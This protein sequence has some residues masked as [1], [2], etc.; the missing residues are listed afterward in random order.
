[1]TEALVYSYRGARS[2]IAL[3][4]LHYRRVEF[5]PLDHPIWALR[6]KSAQFC[7]HEIL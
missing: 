4:S 2:A 5:A 6:H 7:R 1:M 3:D